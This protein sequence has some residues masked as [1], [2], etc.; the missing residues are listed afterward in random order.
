MTTLAIGAGK[1]IGED[2]LKRRALEA[3]PGPAIIPPTAELSRLSSART[4]HEL[5]EVRF[6]DTASL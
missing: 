5:L 6:D 2:R 3:I 1:T 4:G